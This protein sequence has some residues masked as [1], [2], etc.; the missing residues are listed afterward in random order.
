MWPTLIIAGIAQGE[1]EARRRGRLS[2]LA[3][4]LG[5][6]E[7]AVAA[8]TG[9]AARLDFVHRT[10]PDAVWQ[11]VARLV[12]EAGYDPVSTAYQPIDRL[13]SWIAR[14]LDQRLHTTR[15]IFPGDWPDLRIIADWAGATAP[16]LTRMTIT[17]A[18]DLAQR[19]HGRR[20][21]G[22]VW[23]EWR[24]RVD[25]E[26]QAGRRMMDAAVQV[27]WPDGVT[28]V[29]LREKAQ[30]D[31]EG[32]VMNHCV[33]RFESYF[34]GIESGRHR[35]LSLRDPDGWPVLTFQVRSGYMEKSS[36]AIEQVRGPS[37]AMPDPRWEPY[38]GDIH[39]KL[40]EAAYEAWRRR[41]EERKASGKRPTHGVVV[42]T[43][44]DGRRIVKLTTKGALGEEAELMDLARLG[45][46]WT[47]E[48]ILKGNEAVFSLRDPKG[49]PT[50]TAHLEFPK[51]RPSPKSMSITGPGETPVP[52][53]QHARWWTMIH[54][55]YPPGTDL[56]MPASTY[57]RGGPDHLQWIG[58]DHPL[59]GIAVLGDAERALQWAERVEQAVSPD[60]RAAALRPTRID[61]ALGATGPGSEP[62]PVALASRAQRWAEDVAR[63]PDPETWRL[64]RGEDHAAY[65]YL[66]AFPRLLGDDTL[67][68]EVFANPTLSKLLLGISDRPTHRG[69]GFDADMPKEI[70]D[71]DIWTRD[72]VRRDILQTSAGAVALA[73]GPDD[74]PREDTIRAAVRDPVWAL[75]YLLLFKDRKWVPDP[76][77]VESA[78]KGGMDP[79]TRMGWKILHTRGG[80]RSAERPEWSHA[81]ERAVDKWSQRLQRPIHDTL[82]AATAAKRIEIDRMWRT[83]ERWQHPYMRPE[84]WSVQSPATW[85][86][87]ARKLDPDAYAWLLETNWMSRSGSFA[88]LSPGAP[89]E[90]LAHAVEWLPASAV[91]GLVGYPITDEA[92]LVLPALDEPTAPAWSGAAWMAGPR[93]AAR[94][95]ELTGWWDRLG[96]KERRAV[97]GRMEKHRETWLDWREHWRE[98]TGANSYTESRM[99]WVMAHPEQPPLPES[100]PAWI[101]TP[102]DGM[103]VEGLA[104]RVSMLWVALDPRDAMDHYRVSSGIALG[105]RKMPILG[106]F[107][108]SDAAK[109]PGYILIL[110]A[111]MR[112]LDLGTTIGR[113][114]KATST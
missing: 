45:Y 2:E 31:Q 109:R 6:G 50:S 88:Y 3:N 58:R 14:E 24:K 105:L 59:F 114:T 84:R 21:K 36:H 57:Q 48:N 42:H 20:A 27:T 38:L 99:A 69:G 96:E 104:P 81:A 10:F 79:W 107:R 83:F 49:W 72:D 71:L 18:E 25:K 86:E 7:T 17:Q 82:R 98:A 11:A 4:R 19:W 60:T 54:T 103:E 32:E 80:G 87:W 110:P 28:L 78:L 40:H 26:V 13:I 95:K 55:W 68:R 92:S 108:W 1:D 62:D 85:V 106:A 75:E 53:D 113:V 91:M 29:E 101:D 8:L 5:A 73:N 97:R 43:W 30:L 39:V 22:G 112:V 41:M 12:T 9:T 76:R 90:P 77:L 52:R 15:E 89:E 111:R 67:R 33:G 93:R 63:K 44:P 74:G 23:E 34:E 66:L 64:A 16:G 70:R 100:A 47:Q 51:D 46:D 94:A 56:P 65:R 61:P 102:W 35:I 37:N